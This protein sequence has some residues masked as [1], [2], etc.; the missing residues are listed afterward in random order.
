M[1]KKKKKY[2]KARIHHLAFLEWG[3]RVTVDG[4]DQDGV[5][6]G[7]KGLWS[8]RRDDER[9]AGRWYASR[10]DAANALIHFSTY[11]SH[12]PHIKEVFG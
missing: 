8:W 5:V 7:G 2:R 11:G 10:N 9:E 1:A 3:Y 12:D 6:Y 4:Y